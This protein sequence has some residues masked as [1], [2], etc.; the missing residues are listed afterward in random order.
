MC[1]VINICISD[2]RMYSR[3]LPSPIKGKISSNID[4]SKDSSHSV[5][6]SGNIDLL[7]DEEDSEEEID[8][9]EVGGLDPCSS[10]SLN[11]ISSD[12][13]EKAD[14]MLE[15]IFGHSG[16]LKNL[17][18]ALLLG[19]IDGGSDIAL[20]AL[21]FKV[22]ALFSGKHSVRY[23]EA[24]GC[25][26]SGIRNLIKSR[27]LIPFKEH[28]PVP[29]NLS[30]FKKRML[31][32]CGLDP[33]TLG[34]SGLQ[35]KNI[36]LWMDRKKQEVPGQKLAF[37][38]AIDGKKIAVTKHGLEDLGGLGMRET[39]TE[40]GLKNESNKDKL[41]GH[42]KKNDRESHFKLYDGLTTTTGD[43]ISKL[44]ALEELVQ[45]TVK[46]VDKNPLLRKYEF[47]LRQQID[48]GKEILK[49][50]DIIQYEVIAKIASLR[51]S[52]D[53]LPE[54][55]SNIVDLSRQ[56]NYFRLSLGDDNLEKADLNLIE[57]CKLE[58]E[59]FLTLSWFNLLKD[60]RKPLNKF[61]KR[62]KVFISLLKMVLLTDRE[63]YTA[64]GLGR[65]RPFKDMQQVYESCR[66]K[67]KSREEAKPNLEKITATFV[68][69]FAPMTFGKNLIIEDGGMVI[70]EGVCGCP[71]LVVKT[72]DGEN[73]IYSVLFQAVEKERFQCN[74]EMIA[75]SLVNSFLVKSKQGSL[76]VLFS[77][78]N[79]LIYS[80]PTDEKFAVKMIKFIKSYIGK[81]KCL[82]KRSHD[83]ILAVEVMKS[84]LKEKLTSV[85][86]LGRYPI[87]KNIVETSPGEILDHIVQ[88]NS[89]VAPSRCT[90]QGD[91]IL[92]SKEVANFLDST[93]AFLSKQAKELVCVNLSDISGCFS[94]LPHTILAA[95][96]LTSVSLKI[97]VKEVVHEVRDFVESRG[98]ELVNIAV[99]GESLH[100]LTSHSDGT[101]GSE[102]ELVKQIMRKLK[103]FSK[104]EMCQ[105]ISQDK[106]IEI[107]RD[108]QEEI[109]DDLDYCWDDAED[110]NE[111]GAE[112]NL[113][114]IVDQ[115]LAD[116]HITEELADGT[117][118][119]DLEIFFENQ[120][121]S[122]ELKQ[123]R[124]NALK[125]KKV[126]NLRSMG[127]K[128]IF[129][130]VKRSWLHKA[131]GS[132]FISVQSSSG[133]E[134]YEYYPNTVFQ[135]TE[136]G[137]FQTISFDAAHISNLLRES[138]AKGK[139]CELG[140]SDGSLLMLSAK[141]GFDYLKKII[142][143]KNSKLEFDPMNQR[144]S[145]LCFSEKT[146]EGLL[147]IK[148]FSGAK[149]CRLLR[150]GIIESLDTSGLSSEDRCLN[151]WNL[152]QFLYEKINILERIKRPGNK[153]MT[154]ELLQM[155][156]ASCDSHMITSLNIEYHH[157]RRKSTGSVEQFFGQ[158]TMLCDG[159]M[160][161]DCSM[162]SDILSRVTITNALRLVPD[163]VKGFSFLKHLKVHMKSYSVE[164]NSELQ[165][166]Q[167]RY[168][169]LEAHSVCS[170][171]PA[172]SNFDRPNSRKRKTL[173]DSKMVQMDV[174]CLITE[175]EVR[176]HHKKF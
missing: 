146:E 39:T 27:G 16:I 89:K 43:I 102:L 123:K 59:S 34:T 116:I 15:D 165:Q 80:I 30:K 157:P 56:P 98:H 53:C 88:P 2:I 132:E 18:R 49:S 152:K 147:Q 175:G 65:S 176:K 173:S 117:T 153:S 40:K 71:D 81:P 73:I 67:D 79:C 108:E 69:L 36:E 63:I 93:I 131:Y 136:A 35:K 66:M 58:N 7:D 52:Q 4:A 48:S 139:L 128:H 126:S 28:F 154:N 125:V 17:I 72:G 70:E 47:V 144:S 113:L 25:F 163:D 127:L 161:L 155:I 150:K 97:I 1:S 104:E 85:V 170:F 133:T 12:E 29:T 50:L 172:D 23:T 33:M 14:K 135:K 101:S 119:G 95:T 140:L 78:S 62:S 13:L 148:D 20:Q 54:V 19:L 138:A 124:Y 141:S 8:V 130:L 86:L 107:V 166:Q 37:S 24:Y 96:Y 64:C 162:I 106:E 82:K 57:A 6:M 115:H 100:I 160:K 46:Q 74:E 145:S 158:I 77:E 92:L 169:K 167:K 76:L 90:K 60:M 44:A 84:E 68:S 75:T 168:P 171:H 151:I 105:L 32:I 134:D 22:Q 110:G 122:D 91:V 114:K 55:D 121:C 83:M 51:N 109:I 10:D 164:D 111:D 103:G 5:L 38:L 11:H 156:H 129:P 159:G 94:K 99:D 31:E 143:L 61:N 149:C 26:W 174:N 41:L 118:L 112:D 9:A 45:K 120:N 142:S 42:I 87:V 137:L 21:V 3:F